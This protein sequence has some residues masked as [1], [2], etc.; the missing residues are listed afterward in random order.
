MKED[1]LHY[2]RRSNAT[3]NIEY[4]TTEI[5]VTL[6]NSIE[7]FIKN[8]K[9]KKPLYMKKL[10]QFFKCGCLLCTRNHMKL[11][12]PF[13]SLRGRNSPRSTLGIPPSEYE[14]RWIPCRFQIAPVTT[15]QLSQRSSKSPSSNGE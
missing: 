9:R 11:Q 5:P 12:T 1:C 3:E 7:K 2:G 6:E 8:P 13:G 14:G 10:V 4:R 15:Q